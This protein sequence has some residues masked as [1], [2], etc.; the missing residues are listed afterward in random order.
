MGF[1][2][3]VQEAKDDELHPR[4]RKSADQGRSL[5]VA[6]AVSVPVSK[7]GHDSGS[8]PGSTDGKPVYGRR[9]H[10]PKGD[11]QRAKCER[12]RRPQSSLLEFIELTLDM[13]AITSFGDGERE[14]LRCIPCPPP[15][16]E[17]QCADN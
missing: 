13:A 10:R 17:M 1:I 15:S 14:L 16:R 12:D 6:Q 7:R 4:Y 2:L 8:W 9:Q 5:D 3:R 11:R